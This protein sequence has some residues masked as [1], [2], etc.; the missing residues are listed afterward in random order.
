MNS[1]LYTVLWF[2][3]LLGLFLAVVVGRLQTRDDEI[4]RQVANQLKAVKSLEEDY[5]KLSQMAEELGATHRD[6]I[7][8]LL[9][10]SGVHD[11]L[12]PGTL[13]R[14][15]LSVY[16]AIEH[17]DDPERSDTTFQKTVAELGLQG[18]SELQR[19]DLKSLLRLA[20]LVIHSKDK[21]ESAPAFRTDLASAMKEE[22]IFLSD[23]G[24][25][26]L[27]EVL[28]ILNRSDMQSLVEEYREHIPI[29]EELLLS[30]TSQTSQV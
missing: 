27:R 7:L 5:R 15:A 9:R 21:G 13:L 23:G 11:S 24:K 2:L 8:P 20:R 14:R 30:E 10:A 18:P 26:R 17:V 28:S 3:S 25:L 19:A 4:E 29:V 22:R 6:E 1:D 12:T 16:E